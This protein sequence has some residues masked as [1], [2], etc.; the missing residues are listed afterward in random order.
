MMMS[1]AK[2]ARMPRPHL[3]KARD[4]EQFEL[5]RSEGANIDVAGVN[6]ARV[7]RGLELSDFGLEG[8]AIRLRVRGLLCACR[9]WRGR[10]RGGR[11]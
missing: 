4:G 3:T 2:A 1:A 6:A 11:G 8:R 5:L 10:W 7:G 9:P